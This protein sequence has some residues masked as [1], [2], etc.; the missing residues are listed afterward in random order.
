MRVYLLRKR[1]DHI[2][3]C[4][5]RP[6]AL[7]WQGIVWLRQGAEHC[8]VGH[9]LPATRGYATAVC[10]KHQTRFADAKE[11]V[12]TTV[13][14]DAASQTNHDDEAGLLREA[15]SLDPRHTRSGV[16]PAPGA[17]T[18]G[19]SVDVQEA[20]DMHAATSS[21]VEGYLPN[22]STVESYLGKSSIVESYLAKFD[23]VESYLGMSIIMESFLGKSCIVGS[24]LANFNIVDN[25]LGSPGIMK[26]YLATSS[27]VDSYLANSS[28]VEVS[29]S[30][31][32][33]TGLTILDAHPGR[34]RRFP[35]C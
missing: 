4:Q 31:W 8:C 19:A 32:M 34:A 6:P 2:F 14:F 11:N 12:G 25:Y 22:S 3:E 30:P 17:D 33:R 21:I 24:C 1:P 28:I 16:T 5:F 18:A 20:L 26:R 35:R 23:I 27:I 13:A 29:G 10:S 9:K 15:P 7:L